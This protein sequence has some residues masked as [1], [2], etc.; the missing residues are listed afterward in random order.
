MLYIHVYAF[1]YIYTFMHTI[2]MK[3]VVTTLFR[4]GEDMRG[5]VGGKGK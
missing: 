4:N 2:M 5:A 3:E 1:M